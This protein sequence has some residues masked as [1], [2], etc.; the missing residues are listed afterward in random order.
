[1]VEGN[2]IELDMAS[3]KLLKDNE[4]TIDQLFIHNMAVSPVYNVDANVQEIPQ[5]ILQGPYVDAKLRCTEVF[6]TTMSL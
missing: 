3:R 2:N 6:R 5:I 1:M 4:R